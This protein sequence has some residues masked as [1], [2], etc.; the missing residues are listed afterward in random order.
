MKLSLRLSFNDFTINE[1]TVYQNLQAIAKAVLREKQSM[2]TLQ[3]EE[4][5]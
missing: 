3:K 4:R 5:C 1:N 2:P